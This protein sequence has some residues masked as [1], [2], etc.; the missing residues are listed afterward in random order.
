MEMFLKLSMVAIRI[1]E[2]L[3][4]SIYSVAF[5]TNLKGVENIMTGRFT[6]RNE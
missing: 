3:I 1:N 4:G 2:I 6:S 5:E